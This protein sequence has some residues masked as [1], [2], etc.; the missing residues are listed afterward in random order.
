MDNLVT[1]NIRQRPIRSV[2]SIAGVA[3][4]VALVMLFTGLARGMSND[5]QRRSSNVR[6][7]IL[8]TRPGSADNLTSSTA[9]LST[10]YVEEL[11]KI[12]GVESAIPVIRYIYQGGRGFGFEQVE[13]VDWTPF[14]SMNQMRMTEGRAPEAMDE[15]IIDETKAQNG[16]LKVGSILSIFGGKQYRVTG[17][18]APESGARVKMS[19]AAMQYAL[20]APG[21]CTW[22]LIK[23]KDGADQVAVAKRINETLPGNKIQFTRDV[24]TSVEKQIPFLGLFLR[25]LVGLAAVVSALVVMLAMYTTI[26]ERTREIGILKAMGASRAY[27]IGVIEKE[28]IV[29]SVLGLVVGFTVAL[30]SGALIHRIY[31]LM[32]EYGWAWAITAAAIGLFGGVLGALYPAIRAANLDAVSALSY[33]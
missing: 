5:L 9:N 19:L 3:L 25:V 31:G 18:Y 23:C 13:G 8:F 32:F 4:G 12:E 11:Q 15:V 27:I 21:K 28:A 22:I 2:V 24:F 33:E 26:T 6:A 17:I 10:K 14:A 20:E 7:E 30:V 1:A 29:I 16:S